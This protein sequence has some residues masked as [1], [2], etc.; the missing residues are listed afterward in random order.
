MGNEE[1]LHNERESESKSE[2]HTEIIAE[3]VYAKGNERELQG[4]K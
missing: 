1:E 3:R 2:R 4:E